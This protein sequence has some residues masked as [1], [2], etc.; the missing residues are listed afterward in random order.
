MHVKED[1]VVK[2]FL[3][4]SVNFQNEDVFLFYSLIFSALGIICLVQ[5]H[6]AK[7]RY[8]HCKTVMQ[9]SRNKD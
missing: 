3:E 5:Y 7:Q 4:S 8:R 9:R 1:L 2:G 6:M